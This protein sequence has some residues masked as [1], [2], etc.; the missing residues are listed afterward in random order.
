MF[1]ST[2]SDSFADFIVGDFML[3]FKYFKVGLIG[4]V[5]LGGSFV[6]SGHLVNRTNSFNSLGSFVCPFNSNLT[7]SFILVI[8]DSSIL[9][10]PVIKQPITSPIT[11]LPTTPSFS[12]TA[13]TTEASTSI[14]SIIIIS[15]C[16]LGRVYSVDRCSISLSF[17]TRNS[18]CTTKTA[19]ASTSSTLAVI[20]GIIITVSSIINHI[21][22]SSCYSPSV[23]STAARQSFCTF[24]DSISC[25]AL[26]L[27]HQGLRQGS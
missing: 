14:T 26:S 15:S 9:K 19:S 4:L 22:I 17:L 6:S 27:D 5:E 12:N 20:A 16:F 23:F 11:A 24:L 13:V 1:R 10:V 2:A 3:D 21:A 25:H 18:T 8:I 7:C